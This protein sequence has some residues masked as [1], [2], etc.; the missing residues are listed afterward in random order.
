M[1]TRSARRSTH[2][3][4]IT[5][6]TIHPDSHEPRGVFVSTGLLLDTRPDIAATDRE[7]FDDVLQWFNRHLPFPRRVTPDMIFWFRPEARECASRV[8]QLVHLLREHGVTVQTMRTTRP[9][10]IVYSDEMQVGAVPYRGAV[11]TIRVFA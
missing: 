5:S 3:F 9:G 7:Q 10:R 8:W 6:T 11:R 4:R 2:F 1:A